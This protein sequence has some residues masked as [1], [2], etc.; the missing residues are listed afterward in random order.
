M[1]GYRGFIYTP[2]NAVSNEAETVRHAWR[3]MLLR[4]VNVDVLRPR[5]AAFSEL[6]NTF[7]ECKSANWDAEGAAP[8]TEATYEEAQDFLALLPVT[9]R[10]PEIA[11]EPNGSMG[12]EWNKNNRVFVVSVKG[13]R[14]LSY[15]G[16]GVFAP[17]EK[18][19]GSVDFSDSIPSTIIAKIQKVF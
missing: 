12:F 15:A 18:P 8:I 13:R 5:L 2:N 4:L 14:T 11:P 17:G 16:S 3:R 9:I 1:D 19:Y 10:T 6:D 7:D